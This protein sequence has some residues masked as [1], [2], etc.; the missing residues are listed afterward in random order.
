MTT[1]AG[2]R[3]EA[4][5]ASSNAKPVIN[6]SSGFLLCSFVLFWLYAPLVVVFNT[7]VFGLRIRG[8]ENLRGVKERGCIVV[9][10]HS[11]YLDPAIVGQTVFPLRCFYSAMRS[12]FRNPAFGLFLRLMGAFPIPDPS[13]LRKTARTIRE[14]LDRGRPVHFFPEGE[15]THLSQTVA[16]FKSGAFFLALRLGVPIVPVTLVHRP[17]TLFGR[18][19]SKY[20]I[21]VESIIG[22]PVDAERNGVGPEKDHAARIATHV[23]SI[24]VDTI[25]SGRQEPR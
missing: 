9:S 3:R 6:L 15:M 10:N 7:V 2:A 18:K 24:M 25:T 22:R 13:G 12:H 4:A 14:A 16:P 21:R 11:L 20:F 23:R 17:R 8:R 5:A 19:I 1:T